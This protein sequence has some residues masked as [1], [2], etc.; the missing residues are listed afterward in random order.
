MKVKDYYLGNPS[1]ETQRLLQEW[2]REVDSYNTLS[3]EQIEAELT[4]D[5]GYQA[6]LDSL[7]EPVF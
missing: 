4:R 2:Q 3:P 7:D 1:A 6:F 5:K